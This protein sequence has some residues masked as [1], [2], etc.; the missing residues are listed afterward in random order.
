MLVVGLQNAIP[1]EKKPC[2][3]LI[4]GDAKSLV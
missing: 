4:G 1:K 2:K 3:V